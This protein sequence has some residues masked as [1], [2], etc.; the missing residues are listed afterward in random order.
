M[1]CERAGISVPAVCGAALYA[2][3]CHPM[4]VSATD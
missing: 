2:E 3:H 1:H 4:T